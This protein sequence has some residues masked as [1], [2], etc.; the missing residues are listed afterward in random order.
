MGKAPKPQIVDGLRKS[1]IVGVNPKDQYGFAKV[2]FGMIPPTA[3]FFLAQGMEEGKK[4]GPFNYRVKPVQAIIYL[5]AA[6]RHLVALMDGEDFAPDS[7]KHH[8]SAVMANLAIYLDAMVN[9]K[10]IDNRALKGCTGEL[11]ELFNK[12]PG[13]VRTPAETRK[14]L[15]DYVTK[16]NNDGLR[17]KP[18]RAY[19]GGTSKNRNRN[20]DAKSKKGSKSPR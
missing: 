16:V 1:S 13:Q 10:L 15:E 11:T 4:Y 17:S 12:L 5:E 3:F 14:L 6:F 19:S 2:P 20:S 7:G 18:R 9:G 8:G